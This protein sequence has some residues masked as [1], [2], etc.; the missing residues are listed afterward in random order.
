MSKLYIFGIGGTGSRVIKSLVMLLAS[1]VE[2]G[3]DTIVPIIIDRDISTGDYTRTKLLIDKYRLIQKAVPRQ[4]DSKNKFFKTKIELLNNELILKLKDNRQIFK[5]FIGHDTMTIPNK[6]IVEMLF[7][8]ETLDLDMTEGFQGNPNIG[9]IVL[10]QYNESDLFQS[11]ATNFQPGDRIFIISS[12]FGGTG[13]S[14]FPLLRKILHTKNVRDQ[15][16][17]PLPNWGI[18]ND[19]KLGA[20]SVLPYFKVKTATK[21]KNS[22]VDSDTFQD[23]AR[24]ALSYYKTEDKKLDTLYYVADANPTTYDHN[25]G[26]NDQRNEAHL[27]ELAGAL[28]ILDFIDPKQQTINI[29]RNSNNQINRTTYKEFGLNKETLDVDFSHLEDVTKSLIIN[30][31]SQFLLLHKYM[32]QAFEKEKKYQP[33]AKNRFSKDF[34]NKAVIIEFKNFQNEFLNWL[35][36]MEKQERKF[37]PFK[38]ESKNAFDFVKGGINL[39][40]SKNFPYKNWARIDNELNHQSRKIDKSY[41]DIESFFELFSRTIEKLINYSN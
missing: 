13:A 15:H 33:Y 2:C 25:K 21:D 31:L 3:S 23:K 10:N 37:T 4:T 34:V 41:N 38:I 8:N 28:S 14:G 35:K 39:G 29:N 40:E 24:A 12:I 17:N 18:I 11:F 6:A 19:A 5:K 16:N 30:P 9:S 20:I 22:L 7:T 27:V 1:G 32:T 36:E 26:G